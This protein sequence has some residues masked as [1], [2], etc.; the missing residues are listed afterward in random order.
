MNERT[1]EM[2]ITHTWQ[3]WT[4]RAVLLLASAG[5]FI[6]FASTANA[7]ESYLYPGST[8]YISNG[9]G[10]ASKCT[11]GPIVSLPDGGMGFLTA[12]HCGKDGDVVKWDNGSGNRVAVGKLFHPVDKLINGIINDYAVV[13][14]APKYLDMHVAGKYSQIAYITVSDL[15]NAGPGVRLC[16]VGVTSGVRCGGMTGYDAQGYIEADFPSDH[17]DSGG[18]VYLDDTSGGT[19]AIVGILRGHDE[20][21]GSSVIVPIQRALEAYGVKLSIDR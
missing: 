10:K 12:G 16:S 13:S 20:N 8:I 19:V 7:A 11:A 17:G 18:P 15:R 9:D 4:A 6:G 14:V 5:V 3:K 21:D 1:D 2:T